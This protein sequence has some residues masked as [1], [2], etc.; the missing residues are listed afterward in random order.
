MGWVEGRAVEHLC[1]V[2]PV[3]CVLGGWS[4]HEAVQGVSLPI[5]QEYIE[6]GHWCR[7]SCDQGTGYKSEEK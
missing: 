6:W 3:R 7:S 5:R 2:E 1:S 4:H